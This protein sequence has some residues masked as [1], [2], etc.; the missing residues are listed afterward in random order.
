MVLPKESEHE[1]FSCLKRLPQGKPTFENAR[2]K[3]EDL[4]KFLLNK[5]YYKRPIQSHVIR[6]EGFFVPIV[7]FS[8]FSETYHQR[9]ADKLS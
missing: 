3:K 9:K 7:L 2:E 8:S 4:S 6:L 5:L 1:T